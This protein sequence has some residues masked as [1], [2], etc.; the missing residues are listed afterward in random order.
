METLVRYEMLHWKKKEWLKFRKI[1]QAHKGM[2]YREDQVNKIF[3]DHDWK[4]WALEVNN[5]GVLNGEIIYFD[6]LENAYDL[7][8]SFI[9]V[10]DS[11]VCVLRSAL[12]EAQKE[13]IRFIP[14]SN[15]EEVVLG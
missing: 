4:H 2:H 15:F 14:S 1:A 9:L 3:E 10:K 6:D 5:T 13:T 12:T 8:S 11:L 7:E